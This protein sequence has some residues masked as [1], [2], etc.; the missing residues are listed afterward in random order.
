M[1]ECVV[2][3]DGIRARFFTLHEAEFPEYESGPNLV[4]HDDLVN[5]EQSASDRELW[6][7]TST[8]RNRGASGGR[9]HQ[10]D[11][12]RESH[13]EEFSRRFA[14]MVA[15]EAAR[16]AMTH[17]SP[18]VILVAESQMM[19]TARDAVSTSLPNHCGVQVLTKD[20]SKFRPLELHE[21]L[22]TEGL[23]PERRKP[24]VNP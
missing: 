14:Q 9:S 3:I 7:N 16:L 4:E 19:G 8:G 1:N 13:R 23:L 6:A 17:A 21:Y 11:D 2:V 15:A 24:K 18:Q 5:N 20:L 10:Y 12:H 22:A